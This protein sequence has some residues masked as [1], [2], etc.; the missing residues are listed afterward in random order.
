LPARAGR[1]IQIRDDLAASPWR[2]SAEGSLLAGALANRRTMVRDDLFARVL[3]PVNGTFDN[4]PRAVRVAH[5]IGALAQDRLQVGLRE[6][7]RDFGH[8]KGTTKFRQQ[9]SNTHVQN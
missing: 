3:G 7:A 6:V 1:I 9:L 8:A 2:L 5:V 4:A